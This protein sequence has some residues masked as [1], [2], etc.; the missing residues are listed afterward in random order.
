MSIVK[1]DKT[2]PAAAMC[3]TSAVPAT[4]NQLTAKARF[5]Y[6]YIYVYIYMYTYIC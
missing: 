3:A 5:Q 1:V 2:D 4:A 6:I